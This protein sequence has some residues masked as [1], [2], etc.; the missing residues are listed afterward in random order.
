MAKAEEHD[1]NLHLYTEE[2]E[3]KKRLQELPPDASDNLRE[4]LSNEVIICAEA[5]RALDINTLL[6]ATLSETIKN[7]Q[8]LIQLISV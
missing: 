6:E 8:I 4:E 1:K 3:Q 5:S 7:A 2:D